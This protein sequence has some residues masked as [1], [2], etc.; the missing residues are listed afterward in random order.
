[1]DHAFN[2]EMILTVLDQLLI[3]QIMFAFLVQMIM[4][5]MII[6]QILG[7]NALELKGPNSVNAQI[8]YVM[9]KSAILK[10]LEEFAFNV[11]ILM[12]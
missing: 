1:M 9:A 4:D 3:A 7:K 10:M 12:K 2:V 11:G 6:V 5:K 8:V